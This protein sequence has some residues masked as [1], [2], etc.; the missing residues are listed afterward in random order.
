MCNIYISNDVLI[1]PVFMKSE[2]GGCV[3]VW[4]GGINKQC[5]IR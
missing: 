3:C 4:G 1:T 5:R 2:M